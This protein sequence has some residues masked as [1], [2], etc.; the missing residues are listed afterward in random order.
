MEALRNLKVVRALC[1]YQLLLGVFCELSLNATK[2]R[3]RISNR[4]R[5]A[6]P[7][8]SHF[9]SRYGYG[10]GHHQFSPLNE[11]DNYIQKKEIIMFSA[12]FSASH[13]ILQKLS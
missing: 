7:R 2:A 8:T 6:M 3:E 5:V 12:H 4:A 10:R 9:H 13:F 11:Q 1:S